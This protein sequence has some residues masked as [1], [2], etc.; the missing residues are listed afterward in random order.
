[1]KF[2]YLIPLFLSSIIVNDSINSSFDTIKSKK[3]ISVTEVIDSTY[4]KVK[5]DNNQL[6]LADDNVDSYNFFDS[7]FFRILPV[8]VGLLI[9]IIPWIRKKY[10]TRPELTIELVLDKSF[11]ANEGLSR[12]SKVTNGIIQEE[13]EIRLFSL[14]WKYK[15]IIRNNSNITAFYPRLLK[16]ESGIWFT[17]IDKL[18]KLI[19]IK[20][21]D[22]ETIINCEYKKYVEAKPIERPRLN[23]FPDEFK[24]LKIAL[25]YKNSAKIKFFTLFEFSDSKDQN[26]FM[27]IKPKEFE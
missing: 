9:A 10:F 18:N 3:E 15:L 19:P 23:R 13:D 26:K 25:E 12:K 5:I 20:S 17:K 22:K 8:I 21:T 2:I 16:S 7:N 24:D 11:N 1:M 6:E 14:R 4:I 27:K